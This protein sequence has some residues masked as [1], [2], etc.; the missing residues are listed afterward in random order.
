MQ[1]STKQKNNMPSAL[2]HT[3]LRLLDALPRPPAGFGRS[4]TGARGSA[5]AETARGSALAETA[6]PPEAA[7]VLATPPAPPAAPEAAAAAAGGAGDA[8]AVAAGATLATAAGPSTAGFNAWCME[9]RDSIASKN[10]FKV[11]SDIWA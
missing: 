7:A 9:A 5:L 8:A 10:I 6:T 2:A 1:A 4:P 11:S 3:Y